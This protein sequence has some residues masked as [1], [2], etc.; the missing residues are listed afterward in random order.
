MCQLMGMNCNVPT[1]ICFS[2]RGF[3]QRGGRTGD[4]ADGFGVA[5]FEGP[6]CRMFVDSR[7]AVDSPVAAL[8]ATYPIRSQ[9][10]IAHIRKATRGAVALVNTHPFMRE[11][12]GRYWIFAHNGTLENFR[13]TEGGRYRP[14]GSTDS[15]QA[16]CHLLDGLR[17][18]FPDGQ[19]AFKELFDA[20]ATLA[21][22]I[23]RHGRFNFILSNGDFLF[24]H[25]TDN[26]TYVLRHAP[27]TTAH[28]KD[29]DIEVDF[30]QVT[31]PNDRI[32]VVATE[33]L[34]DNERWIPF[35]AGQLLAFRDGAPVVF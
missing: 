15:E 19:P 23:A 5:F 25:C 7:P 6:G 21:A 29:Q 12:W 32:A 33:P 16:F 9:N 10:V 31:T 28:L 17:S 20:I 22:D 30:S 2:F 1:D 8:I 4:H 34:T 11:L 26:L 14:V 27:F 3:H 35:A 18:R 13:A 24:A